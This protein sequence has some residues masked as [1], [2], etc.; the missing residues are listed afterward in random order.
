VQYRN[1]EF[2]KENRKERDSGKLEHIILD[3]KE[4]G[5]E[6]EVHRLSLP[7]TTS[8]RRVCDSSSSVT[9]TI[10]GHWKLRRAD[11]S[12]LLFYWCVLY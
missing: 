11:Y 7:T 6:A 12:I 5:S 10:F 3:R 4:R 8:A 1:L 2:N 9:K